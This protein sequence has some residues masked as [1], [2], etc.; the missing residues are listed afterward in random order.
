ML[1]VKRP[2]CRVFCSFSFQK[3][4]VITRIDQDIRIFPRDQNTFQT[5]QIKGRDWLQGHG[6]PTALLA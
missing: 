3:K 6:Y 5:H 2:K 1:T 4:Q